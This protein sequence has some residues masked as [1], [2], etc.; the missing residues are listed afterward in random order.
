MCSS[1]LFA[2]EHASFDD[3]DDT[4]ED[5]TA[6]LSTAEA[7]QAADFAT[8][9]A[10]ET[11]STESAMLYGAAEQ[12]QE[13][14]RSQETESF[15]NEPETG[16]AAQADEQPPEP[17]GETDEQSDLSAE[18]GD[19]AKAEPDAAAKTD[20]PIATETSESQNTGFRPV[21]FDISRIRDELN[22]RLEKEIGRASWR[23]RVF[24]V[25]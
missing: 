19:T 20:L 4:A 18:H 5:V 23:E 15:N 9:V 1:V 16:D 7:A 21:R 6:N 22:A 8:E 25:V 2:V 17:S 14:D 12:E 10:D 13:P 11:V 24:A 3:A